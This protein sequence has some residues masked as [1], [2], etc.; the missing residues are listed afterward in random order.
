MSAI[1]A[2]VGNS[3]CR[4]IILDAIS[5]FSS[6]SFELSGIA[7][8]SG[9]KIETVRIKGNSQL[10]DSNSKE[11]NSDARI[12][13]GESK[14][15]HRC[16]PSGI[17]APPSANESFCAVCCGVIENFDYLKKQS[18]KPFPIATDEDLLL[19]LL[20]QLSELEPS[21]VITELDKLIEGEISYAF[22]PAGEDALY[23]KAGEIPLTVGVCNDG[24]CVSSELSAAAPYIHRYCT[25]ENNETAKITAGKLTVFDRRKR[26]IKKQLLSC[27]AGAPIGL[28]SYT[29]DSPLPILIK[30]TVSALMP[31]GR[32]DFDFLRLSSRAISKIGR[33]IITGCGASYRAALL[34]SW[35]IE[36]FCDIP[37][38]SIE[39]G[40]LCE[41]GIFFDRGT[42]LIAISSGGEERDVI[43]CVRRA[44]SFQSLTLGITSGGASSLDTECRRMIDIKS[45][46]APAPYMYF[47]PLL[48]LSL[49]ALWLGNKSEIISDLYLSVASRLAELLPGKISSAMK[50]APYIRK[51]AEM[52]I[53]SENIFVTGTGADSALAVEAACEIRRSLSLNAFPVL[54]NEL[55]KTYPKLLGGSVVIFFITDRERLKKAQYFIR[56]FSSLGAQ[57]IVYTTSNIENELDCA[58][59]IVPIT[60]SLPIFDTAVTLS[61][62][63]KTTDTAQDIL[64]SEQEQQA[65]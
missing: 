27:T 52:I 56:R 35:Y 18:T 53:S 36:A 55:S 50:N 31:D 38:V 30:H 12:G 11:M 47:P 23:V 64:A 5:R 32:P 39:A 7:L 60:D 24:Y 44:N 28:K 57:I 65:G 51:S 8:K 62:L 59:C 33:I 3:P 13:L 45:A 15:A 58:D 41:A 22:I 48:T 10:L 61:A 43:S 63:L 4:D 40:E 42:L 49:F 21:Q 2:Y 17:T 16:K 9:N 14:M 29:A 26:K 19:A 54:C 6:E 1:F 37:C 34:S 46:D 20:T 25:L